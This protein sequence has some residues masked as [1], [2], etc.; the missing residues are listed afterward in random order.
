MS[1][2]AQIGTTVPGRSVS[3]DPALI[4]QAM[5]YPFDA[6]VE[7]YE[8][9]EG[10]PHVIA[11]E[12]EREVKRYLLLCAVNPT[13]NYGMKG[14]VDKLWHT[15]LL[16]TVDYAHFCE[17]IAGRFIHHVPASAQSRSRSGAYELFLADYAA[18]FGEPAPV[19][20][21]PRPPIKMPDG[22]SAD[23]SHGNCGPSCSP[24]CGAE[25]C[26]TK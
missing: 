5:T 14:P 13:A 8:L 22:E 2:T 20:L 23:C 1:V 11:R 12:H 19:H 26:G 25:G 17:T 16:F 24:S 4:E 6:I 18:T 9:E 15:F 21:W 3:I 10:V 7:R